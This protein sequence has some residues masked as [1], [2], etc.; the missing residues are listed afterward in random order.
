MLFGNSY[1]VERERERERERVSLQTKK[2]SGRSV[3]EDG[4]FPLIRCTL[5]NDERLGSRV[6]V[7]C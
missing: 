1:C 7:V 2:L 3:G 6:P 4:A 5:S